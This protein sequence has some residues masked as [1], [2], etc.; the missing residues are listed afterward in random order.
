MEIAAM[1]HSYDR[2]ADEVK[3]CLLRDGMWLYIISQSSRPGHSFHP[4]C[5]VAMSLL[6]T[7]TAMSKERIGGCIIDCPASLRLVLFFA[8]ILSILPIFKIGGAR[9]YSSKTPQPSSDCCLEALND[10]VS[11]GASTSTSIEHAAW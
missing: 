7:T 4:L 11:T 6:M 10:H 1:L 2:R 8:A 3:S 9:V 5:V